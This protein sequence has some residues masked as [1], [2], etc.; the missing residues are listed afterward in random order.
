MDYPLLKDQFDKLIHPRLNYEGIR[1]DSPTEE[2]VK[3]S[4]RRERLREIVE[5]IEQ[6]HGLIRERS[7]L[8]RK[9]LN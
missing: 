3:D 8:L 4:R 1:V 5:R 2:I 6:Q 7:A 9:S